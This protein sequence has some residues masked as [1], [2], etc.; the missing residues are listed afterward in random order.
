MLLDIAAQS[1]DAFPPLKSCLGGINALIKHYD[2]RSYQRVLPHPLTDI[3]Q[4][5]KDVEDELES[6]IPWLTKLN[7]S[8]TK[9]SA[10]DTQEE[11]VRR[12][13]LL[14]FVPRFHLADPS[15]PSVGPWKTSRNDLGRCR[16]KGWPPESLIKRRTLKKLS[17][18][19]KIFGERS[20]STRWAPSGTVGI[21]RSFERAWNSYRNSDQ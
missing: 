12:E 21:G 13:Q 9:G 14:R 20:S 15:Q 4:Q 5:S 2:V 16:E 3:P 17:S 18:W 1:A 8:L 19:W 7:N 10:D 6:L 11:A